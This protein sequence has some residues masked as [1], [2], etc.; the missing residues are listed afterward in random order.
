MPSWSAEIQAQINAVHTYQH[1]TFTFL[2]YCEHYIV[3]YST[4][5]VQ[6]IKG[7]CHYGGIR[8]LGANAGG[9]YP[10]DLPAWVRGVVYAD[11]PAE[12]IG[13][14]A[15]QEA[16][17][18]GIIGA[19][20]PGNLGAFAAGHLPENLPAYIRGFDFREFPAFISIF[21]VQNLPAD[22]FGIP[23]ED[24][25][26][27]LKVWPQEDLP[28]FIHGWDTKDLGA[29][30]NMIGYANLPAVI[31]G[32][33]PANI[34]AFIR[35]WVRE[36]TYDLQASIQ[37]FAA[38]DLGAIIRG[39][40]MEQLSAYLFPV[41]PRNISAFI[42]GWQEADLSAEIDVKDYPWNLTAAITGRPWK[43]TD[44]GAYIL[45]DGYLGPHTNLASY[46]L[47]TQGVNN[48]PATMGIQQARNLSAYIDPGRDLGNLTAEIYPKRL[49]LTGILSVITMEHSDLSATIS[50]PC[51]FS[52]LRNL[53]ALINPVFQ[54]NLSA[55]IYAKGYIYG[56]K[57]LSA[58]IGYALY[59]V[60][61]DKLTISVN[62]DPLGFRTEDKYNISVAIFRSGLSLGASI[63][64]QRLPVDLLA[65]INAVDIAPYDFDN[66]KGKERV[67]DTTYGQILKDYEDVTVS[68]QT[69]VKDYFYSSGSDVVAKVD[70]Y[71]H[72]VTKVASYFSP[73]TAR[74]L[75]R[76]SHKVKYLYDMRHFDTTDEAMRYAIWYVTTT[77][78]AELGAYINSI[79]P[80]GTEE[81]TARIGA[82]RWYSTDNNL[83]SYIEGKTTHDYDVI[84]AYTD[85]GVGYLEF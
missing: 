16:E 82:T 34:R 56:Q 37:G 61:Q 40:Y 73:E 10:G 83:T 21:Q 66:W 44:L 11:L 26:A 43:T 62:I 47:V 3:G 51:F 27:Y 29:Y 20:P 41:V 55:S 67:Y 14:F 5:G 38:E 22:I 50:V 17:L 7:K 45:P 6:I 58:S 8:D 15:T 69:I 4:R 25:S 64:A 24:L 42:Y 70:R 52:D 49:R 33:R 65:Y 19:H 76:T 63:T 1:E 68:F 71:T 18:G 84:I 74:K 30:L 78:S 85:D 81:L 60:V 72:F 12:I 35:G 46:I 23:P 13:D 77:P 32:H 53:S 39:T 75:G 48:L 36:A 57:N 28:G 79:V 59:T 2:K 9:H 31:G 80:R 54:S